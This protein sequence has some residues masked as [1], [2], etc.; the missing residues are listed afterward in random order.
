[1]RTN[2]SVEDLGGLLEQPLVATLATYRS[3]GEV[4][5]SPV[6]FEWQDGGFNIVVG[7]NDYKAQH[8][9]RDPRASV[10]VYEH[11]HPLRGVELR[12]TARLFTDGLSEIRARIWHHYGST[13][14]AGPDEAEIGVRIE[15]TVRAWDFAD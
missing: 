9:R 2:L 4:L 7:R 13:D 6:W 11:E 12:G 10:A 14:P 1:M 8:I 3:N 15:G 5:L